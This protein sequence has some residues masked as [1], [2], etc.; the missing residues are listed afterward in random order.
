MKTIILN[1][2]AA[3]FVT[4]VMLPGA[5]DSMAAT[6]PVQEG[7]EAYLDGTALNDL[8]SQGWG[9]SS[10]TVV[11]RTVSQAADPVRGT[12][13]VA[14]P[15]GM[16]ASNSVTSVAFSNVWVEM[17]LDG[18]MGMPASTVG[19]EG[20]DSNM[21]VQLFLDP[22]G[23]PVVWNPASN[24][25]VVCTQDIW[26][27]SVSTFNTSQWERLTICQN[28]SNK[29][30]SLF[31]NEHL[32]LT[33]LPFIDTNRT[34][35]GRFEADG[36]AGVTSYLDEVSM[37]YTPPVNWTADLDNDG[38]TDA[39]EIQAYGNMSAWRRLV[40]TDGVLGSG[41]SIGISTN[42]IIP[43]GAV[44]CTMTADVAYAVA[45]LRTN[46]ATVA[47]FAGLPRTVSYTVTNLWTD[48]T[49]TGVFAYTAQ[50]FVPLDYATL[51]AAVAAAV[52]GDTIIADSGVYSNAL[53]LDKSL[54][55]NGTN[56]TLLGALTVAGGMTGT[57][58]G[59]QGLVVS[60]GV[61][62]ASGGRLVVSNGTANVGTL[63]V[64]SG[65]TV[66]VVNATAFIVNGTTFAGNVTFF[67][68]WESVL[69]PQ[70][71]PYADSFERYALAARLNQAGCFGWTASSDG[72][73]VQTNQVQSGQAV[74]VPVND[75]LSST[76]SAS[77]TL[78]VWIEFYYQDTSRIPCEN[79]T[80]D[81][82]DTNLA[83]QAFISTNGYVTLYNPGL[84]QWDVCSNDAQG[85]S[86]LPLATEAWPRLT[87]N[88]NYARGRA[89]VFLNGRL[90][91]QQLRFINTNLVNSGHFELDGGF[92]GPS[93]MDTFRVQTD[94]IG[95]V[96]DDRD[97]D[98]CAD[99]LE[100]DYFGN[101]FQSPPAGSGAVYYIR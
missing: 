79:V 27:T 19:A 18:S 101:T 71:P 94:S 100:I 45:S 9:A 40:I 77:G 38:M 44:I 56:M 55:L 70:T 62:V 4:L 76:M 29:T 1:W 13:A 37:R 96:S 53:T 35:Y 99:A 87:F 43:G 52:V 64:Q 59:C 67:S 23:H 89:A 2:A 95:I 15:Q 11:I 65:G 42:S 69:V 25:W 63:T 17:Y 22:A 5:P 83:V 28:Y 20:V 60:G 12:N 26:H 81:A 54:T 47:S 66:Q 91:R 86:V 78:N 58:S 10:N 48:T 33:G 80:A 74:V 84:G 57:L 75:I 51:Q 46:G 34:S 85:V 31:M 97:G 41:G 24:A 61:T 72:I 50:R 14:I 98:G 30:A 16:I 88:Q 92:S 36:G 21:T 49:V 90:L 32:L 7:F 93:Y 3:A 82:V 39:Q 73:V 6:L 68:G 8:S